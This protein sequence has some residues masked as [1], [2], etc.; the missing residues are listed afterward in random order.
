MRV[1]CMGS[2]GSHLLL[3]LPAASLSTLRSLLLHLLL[4][5]FTQI[6]LFMHRRLGFKEDAELA[7]A[8]EQ[9][10][11]IASSRRPSVEGHPD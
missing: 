7:A 11:S 3:S 9:R 10:G 4:Y 6:A 2:C 8:L 5:F 1:D